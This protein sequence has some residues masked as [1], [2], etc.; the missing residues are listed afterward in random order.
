[1][2]DIHR[3]IDDSSPR[4]VF[5]EAGIYLE[6]ILDKYLERKFSLPSKAIEDPAFNLEL[7]IRIAEH[8]GF[9]VEPYRTNV[10]EI[11]RIRNRYAHTLEPEEAA[12]RNMID[13]METTPAGSLNEKVEIDIFT[14]FK[15]KAVATLVEL[16]NAVEADRPLFVLAKSE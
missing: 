16:S 3:V 8:A 14:K 12:I 7:K 2:A 11:Q 4:D 5:I 15:I 9:L 6:N 13:A 10:R 1:M